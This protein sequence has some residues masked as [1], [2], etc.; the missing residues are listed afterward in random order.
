M[1]LALEHLH[2]NNIIYRDLKP[3]NVLIG[4]DGYIKITDFGLSKQNI[5]D[6]TSAKSFCGTPE[7]LAPE[8]VE[9]KGHGKA[10]DW[11]S[12][13]AIVFEMLT[14]MP[15]FYS[16]EREKLFNNIKNVNIKYPSYLSVNAVELLKRLFEYDPEKRL[17]SGPTGVKD[18]KEMR[19][20]ANIDWENILAKKI[21]PPFVPKI[22]GKGDTTYIDP[23]FT[24]ET[25]IDSYNAGDSL[26]SKDDP[27]KDGFSYNQNQ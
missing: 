22:S 19:F 4:R 9:Q 15:P 17:G 25:P 23:E 2:E 6:N 21:K 24:S 11:W 10:V 20:F 14:G 7:Y 27:Y 26:E 8:I 16:K 1:V 12:L 3:E 5:M 18:I 13:G